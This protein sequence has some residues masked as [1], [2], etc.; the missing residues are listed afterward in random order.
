LD[1]KVILVS[2]H[3][4]ARFLEHPDLTRASKLDVRWAVA[5]EQRVVDRAAA[6]VCPSHYMR[7]CFNETYQFSGLVQVIPNLLDIDWLQDIEAQDPRPAM[8]LEAD[9]PLIYLPAAGSRLKGAAYLPDLIRCLAAQT[10]DPLG[11]YLPGYVEPEVAAALADL[12][13]N[14]RLHRTGQQPYEIHIAAVKACSFGI[15][16]SLMENYSMAL[17]EAVHCG[18][19]MLA[20]DTGGNS[21]IIRDGRNGALVPEGDGAALCAAAAHLLDAA[22]LQKLR[23]NALEFSRRALDPAQAAQAYVELIQSL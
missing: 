15:S 13:A 19:P 18:L 23:T 20:F 12:P 6:V 3:N 4:P 8:G 11:F 21:D 17:L 14:V 9:A 16:P 22:T 1:A 10:P 5:L 2:H 7:D